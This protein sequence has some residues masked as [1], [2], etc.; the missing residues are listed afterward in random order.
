MH[1][2]W[3]L[4]RRLRRR[5]GTHDHWL[6]SIDAVQVPLHGVDTPAKTPGLLAVGRGLHEC[7]QPVGI[8]LHFIGGRR[9]VAL[10]ASSLPTTTGIDVALLCYASMLQA[11]EIAATR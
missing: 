10:Y 5:Q 4:Y 3:L 6:D 1:A 7:M 11:D 9:P 2:A 8:S